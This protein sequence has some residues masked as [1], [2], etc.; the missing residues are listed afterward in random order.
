MVARARKAR[1]RKSIEASESRGEAGEKAGK[2]RP[3]SS[4]PLGQFALSSPAELRLDWRGT[5]RSLNEQRMESQKNAELNGIWTH[6]LWDTG[7]VLYQLSCRAN[8]DLVIFWEPI[9]SPYRI[10]KWRD[11]LWKRCPHSLLPMRTSLEKLF[12][13]KKSIWNLHN[14]KAKPKRLPRFNPN[15]CLETLKN[16]CIW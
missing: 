2:V 6:H 13:L 3:L 15:F 4:F 1:V 14:A 9:L 11:Y 12:Y 8:W 7:V 16:K 10:W 5:A